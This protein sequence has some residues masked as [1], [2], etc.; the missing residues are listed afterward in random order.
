MDV[1]A[2]VSVFFELSNRLPVF[3]MYRS[4]SKVTVD[5]VSVKHLLVAEIP[6]SAYFLVALLLCLHFAVLRI[7]AGVQLAGLFGQSVFSHG[8]NGNG[9]TSK[10]P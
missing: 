5:L 9:Q 1:R 7:P 3:L 4:A 8:S 2:T 6:L 10:A